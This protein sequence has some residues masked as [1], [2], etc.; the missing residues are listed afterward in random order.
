MKNPYDGDILECALNSGIK[1]AAQKYDVDRRYVFD[2]VKRFKDD[3]DDG[4]QSHLCPCRLAR[5]RGVVIMCFVCSGS[6]KGWERITL[7]AAALQ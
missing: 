2:L 1:F 3:I 7:S 5:R 6:R 4:P